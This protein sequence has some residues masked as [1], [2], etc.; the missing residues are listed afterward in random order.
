M[1]IRQAI[2]RARAAQA[3]FDRRPG[4]QLSLVVDQEEGGIEEAESVAP[5]RGSVDDV[6]PGYA[7]S[8]CGPKHPRP[9]S[10][11]LA[12]LTA[13]GFEAHDA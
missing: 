4:S 12:L 7:G 6:R 13:H 11:V 8:S 5:G 9:E 2:A 10:E 1:T 3:R